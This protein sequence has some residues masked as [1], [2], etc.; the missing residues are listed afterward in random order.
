M[1]TGASAASVKCEASGGTTRRGAASRACSRRRSAAGE[2]VRVDGRCHMR[3]ALCATM[4]RSLGPVNSVIHSFARPSHC[5]RVETF[6]QSATQQR[7][8]SSRTFAQHKLSNGSEHHHAML[9]GEDIAGACA[10]LTTH[11]GGG[12]SKVESA[13]G[14]L[15]RVPS[16]RGQLMAAMATELSKG[17]KD[18]TTTREKE[19]RPAILRSTPSLTHAPSIHA[20]SRLP[21]HPCLCRAPC[22]NNSTRSRSWRTSPAVRPRHSSVHKTRPHAEADQWL[23]FRVAQSRCLPP[24][25]TR[26]TAR[27]SSLRPRSSSPPC[28]APPTHPSA[29]EEGG[30]DSGVAAV[31]RQVSE[32]LD[33]VRTL[34]KRRR[35]P[36]DPGH[37]RSSHPPLSRSHT[38]RPSTR[39][40]RPPPLS[41]PSLP[42]SVPARSVLQ[43]AA[44]VRVE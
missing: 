39:S 19:V 14:A 30:A 26:A 32:S 5:R 21:P 33:K 1:V 28:T 4:R 31:C 10:T 16:V 36:K 3:Y 42:L 6:A 15:S 23:H 2:E 44:I 29:C 11:V 41:H 37:K 40:H 35:D 17:L 20:F 22:S 13:A 9:I 43:R 12:R 7:P 25:C 34:I 24:C 38:P 8:Q 27:R 18:I